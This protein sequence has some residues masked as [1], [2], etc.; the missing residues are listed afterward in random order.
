[1]RFRDDR[2]LSA[3]GAS[4]ILAWSHWWIATSGRDVRING[5]EAARISIALGDRDPPE[6]ALTAL[7][8]FM[9][10]VPRALP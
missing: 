7:L 2:K 8:F 4:S 6:A 5:G 1:M 9:R 3:E 10:T